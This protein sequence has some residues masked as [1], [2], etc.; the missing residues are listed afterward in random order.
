MFETILRYSYRKVEGQ[1]AGLALFDLF[2]YIYIYI[3]IYLRMFILGIPVHI[4]LRFSKQNQPG[5]TAVRPMDSETPRQTRN[6]RLAAVGLDTATAA[7][8]QAKI[9]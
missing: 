7:E 5:S 9:G 3:Y 2:I 1:F 6:N 8:M 4:V